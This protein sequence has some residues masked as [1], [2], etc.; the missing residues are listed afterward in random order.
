MV[1][2]YFGKMRKRR[3][4]DKVMLE[5]IRKERVTDPLTLKLQRTQAGAMKGLSPRKTLDE[6]RKAGMPA[7]LMIW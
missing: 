7:P 6:L 5:G 1:I 4:T 3:R 2:D